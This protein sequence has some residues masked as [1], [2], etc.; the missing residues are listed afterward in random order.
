[1]ENEPL[2]LQW[3]IN[4]MAA[5]GFTHFID[6]VF[7]RDLGDSVPYKKAY[8]NLMFVEEMKEKFR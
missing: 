7:Y 1:M 3:I 8:E 4:A 5:M 6:G 2:Y